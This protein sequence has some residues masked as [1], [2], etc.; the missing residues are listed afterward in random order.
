M[1]SVIFM[2]LVVVSTFALLFLVGLRH[3]RVFLSNLV[4]S[5]PRSKLDDFLTSNR[6]VSMGWLGRL[7]D[8]VRSRLSS[9]VLVLRGLNHWDRLG[10]WSLG[11]RSWDSLSFGRRS[12]GFCVA[13]GF[14]GFS[15]LFL[16]SRLGC[17]GFLGLLSRL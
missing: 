2:V 9:V 13:V 8:H 15:R 7:C 3:W 11:G 12:L 5:L 14:L 17:C 1:L 16:S 10:N 4:I 6:G